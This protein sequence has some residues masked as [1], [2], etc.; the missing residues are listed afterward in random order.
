V[1][2]VLALDPEILGRSSQ[3]LGMADI[4]AP[5]LWFCRGSGSPKVLDYVKGSGQR[6]SEMCARG[7]FLEILRILL[8]LRIG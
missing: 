4:L 5:M 3:D 6:D 8:E 7:T 1:D 2:G